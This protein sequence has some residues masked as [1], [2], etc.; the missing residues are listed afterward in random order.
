MNNKRFLLYGI[1]LAI[2]AALVYVQFRSWS[3]FD[4]PTFWKEGR[5]LG[6]TPNIF[7]IIHAI[8]L[9][10]LSYVM[11]AIRWK[12]FLR[13]VQPKAS[14]WKLISPTVVGF[15]GLALF[16]RPGELIRPYLISRRQDLALSS[17]LAVWTIERICDIGAFTVLLVAAAFLATAPK[18][19]A[20]YG[21]FQ[22]AGLFLLLVVLGMVVAAVVVH[23]SGEALANWVEH[24]FSH[25]ASGLGHKI[26]ARIR[27]FRDGLDTIHDPKSFLQIVAVSI[28]MWC[29]I[30]VAYKEVT[31]AYG[32]QALEIPQTQVLLLMGSSMVGSLIQLPGVGGGSQLATIAALEHIFEVPRE[33]AASCGISLWLVTFVSVVPLG[34]TLAH[35]ERLSLRKLTKESHQKEA[36]TRPADY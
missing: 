7:H 12:I 10:Y 6:R 9:I 3:A 27:E 28:V 36:S 30:A 18:R 8:L 31:H 15:T 4:W 5:R 23:R 1:G 35:R 22:Q 33:M 26:A 29:M 25:L 21:S 13:P 19:L 16:G 34:L 32:Q 11:R 24:K 20:Y 2:L 17:Q 14:A